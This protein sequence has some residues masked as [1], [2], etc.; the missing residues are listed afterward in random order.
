MPSARPTTF[1]AMLSAT[2][3]VSPSQWWLTQRQASA[4]SM[5]PSETITYSTNSRT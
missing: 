4:M 2:M 5:P 1:V 3:L